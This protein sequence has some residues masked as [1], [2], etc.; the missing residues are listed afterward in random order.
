M[1]SL[2]LIKFIY[3]IHRNNPPS[4]EEIESMGLLAVKIAQYYALRADFIDE[5]TCV[6]LS[7]LYE[8]SYSAEGRNIE[9]VIGDDLWILDGL[10]LY[11]KTPFSSASIGQVHV[12]YLRG[13]EGK[14]VAIKIRKEDFKTSFFKDIQDAKRIANLLLFFYP[15]LKKVFNPLEVLNNIEEGTLRELDFK[16]EIEGAKYFRTL[17]LENTKKFNLE[18]L[19]F[20]EFIDSLSSE[21]VAVSKFIEGESFNLLLKENRLKYSDLLRLFKYHTFFMFKLGVFHGDLHP[22]NIILGK[23][24]E[25][26]LIDCSTIG[27]M[28]CKLRKGL[29]GFFYYLSRY[30]Y[31]SAGFYLNKMSEKTLSEKEM[32][33]FLIKFKE[34]YRDFK[35][36]S[37]SNVSLTKRMMETIKLAVNS[38]MEFEE[39]MFHVIKSLMY[40]DGMVLKC[41]P[42]VNLMEDIRE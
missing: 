39:G 4:L 40:L 12:G 3:K 34:L 33:I 29:F 18:D 11:E 26:N 41:N 13:G 36:S 23:N 22:G 10:K 2:K 42:T 25:I 1:K 30:D 27:R 31:D 9:D 16:N 15:K 17:K 5:K 21:K 37:V 19:Y 38:G 6:Y 14:K 32:G 20:S 28:K 8:Y 35:D 7:K 24:G